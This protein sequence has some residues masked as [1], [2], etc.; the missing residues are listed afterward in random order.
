[1]DKYFEWLEVV[2]WN[3]QVLAD[4]DGDTIAPG[5][6]RLILSLQP[7]AKRPRPSAM[8]RLLHRFRKG[9]SCECQQPRSETLLDIASRS[10]PV[11]RAAL[12]EIEKLQS[13]LLLPSRIKTEHLILSESEEEFL[14]TTHL[15]TQPQVQLKLKLSLSTSGLEIVADA[16]P[17]LWLLLY[18]SGILPSYVR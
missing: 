9:A 3:N 5:T 18:L 13:N 4:T 14:L 6:K 8:A 17:R 12:A 7:K 1:M 15:Q 10:S 11:I 2:W 16:P